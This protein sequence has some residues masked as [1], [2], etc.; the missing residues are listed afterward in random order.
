M[1]RTRRTDA[2]VSPSAQAAAPQAAHLFGAGVSD[3][4]GDDEREQQSPAASAS[5]GQTAGEGA[6]GARTPQTPTAAKGTAS[7]TAKTA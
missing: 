7:R 2:R 1:P 4:A 6:R 3:E 5:S